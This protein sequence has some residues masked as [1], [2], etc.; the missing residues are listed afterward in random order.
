[1][2]IKNTVVRVILAATKSKQTVPLLMSLTL[3]A[4]VLVVTGCQPPHH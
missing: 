2:N 4:A 1:M 3:I